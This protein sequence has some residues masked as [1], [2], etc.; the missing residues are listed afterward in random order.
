MGK[1]R[2]CTRVLKFLDRGLVRVERDMKLFIGISQEGPVQLG[3]QMQLLS[4][5]HIPKSLINN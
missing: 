2:D 4:N 1:G 3:R 5:V